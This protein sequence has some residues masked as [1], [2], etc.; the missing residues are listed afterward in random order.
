[1]T[2]AARRRT[3]E[4]LGIEVPELEHLYTFTYHARYDH[5]SSEYEMCGVFIGRNTAEP[6]VNTRE[7][8]NWKWSSPE[9]LDRQLQT[10]PARHSPWLHLEWASLREQYW[11]RVLDL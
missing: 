10:N 8:A 3:A 1:M 5:T 7:I 11:E 2:E 6:E 4:E 9:E